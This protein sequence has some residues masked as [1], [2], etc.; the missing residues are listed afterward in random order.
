MVVLRSYET[1]EH[2]YTVLTFLMVLVDHTPPSS[3]EVKEWVELYFHS[4]SKPSRRGAQL[5][6]HRDKFTF[7][8]H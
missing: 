2:K 5:K 3:A 6:K 7:Y 1:E 8:I 4:P